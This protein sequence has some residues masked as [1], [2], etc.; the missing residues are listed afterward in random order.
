MAKPQQDGQ[1]K[2]AHLQQEGQIK[3][4]QSAG[5]RRATS[6]RNLRASWS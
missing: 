3:A 6:N 1:I 2:T 4:G 5:G